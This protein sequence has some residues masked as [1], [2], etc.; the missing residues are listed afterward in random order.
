MIKSFYQHRNENVS[1]GVIL[2]WDELFPESEGFFIEC[3]ISFSKEAKSRLA[4]YPP[5]PIHKEISEGDL[6]AFARGLLEESKTKLT[7]ATKLCLTLEDKI[8]Y[9]THSQNLE[10]Y[11]RIGATVKNIKKVLR[12][13]QSDFLKRWV[14]LNTEGRNAAQL[15]GNEVL[16]NF[17]KLVVNSGSPLFT[18]YI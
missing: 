8:G 10:Y 16:K 2:D 17:Y 15:E 11:S 6:S 5:A 18:L 4:G 14:D 1:K 13:E 7:P 12:F 9:V 3:D